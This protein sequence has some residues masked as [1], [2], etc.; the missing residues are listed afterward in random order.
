[1]QWNIVEVAA[2]VSHK[3]P[4]GDNLIQFINIYVFTQ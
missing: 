1:M 4:L 2:K 3:N